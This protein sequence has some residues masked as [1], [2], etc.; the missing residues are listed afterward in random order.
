[1]C[2]RTCASVCKCAHVHRNCVC[3]VSVCVCT[4]V[5]VSG[6]QLGSRQAASQD[7]RQPGSGREP[8]VP[9]GRAPGVTA[10]SAPP[11]RTLPT[12]DLV[13]AG[14]VWSLGGGLEEVRPLP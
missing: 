1:M 12:L 6:T 8:H 2:V 10:T 3:G 11:A 7:R 13:T 14:S 9:P 4:R 5:D